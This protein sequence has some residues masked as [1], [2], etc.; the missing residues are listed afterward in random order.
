MRRLTVTACLIA[1]LAMQGQAQTTAPS[2]LLV[3]RNGVC[4]LVPAPSVQPPTPA[5]TAIQVQAQP[6]QPIAAM[7]VPKGSHAKVIVITAVV[8]AAGTWALV[9]LFKRGKAKK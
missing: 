6:Y 4:I 5:P 9:K 3:C 7:Q 1:G 2:H 8:S